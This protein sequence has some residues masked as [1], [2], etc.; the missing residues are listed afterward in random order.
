MSGVLI[1]LKNKDFYRSYSGLSSNKMLAETLVSTIKEQLKD[2][3]LQ[4]NKVGRLMENYSFIKSRPS[5]I[6]KNKDKKKQKV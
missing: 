5:L 3:D 2:E 1:A 6:H 4:G